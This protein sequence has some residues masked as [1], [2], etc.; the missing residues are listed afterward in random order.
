MRRTLLTLA[1][2]AVFAHAATAEP[3][4]PGPPRTPFAP[5]R[6]LVA[7]TPGTVIAPS[8]TPGG[9][10]RSANVALSAALARQGIVRSRRLSDAVSTDAG[11]GDILL[12]ESD[13]ADFDPLSAAADLRAL[14][15]VTGAAPDLHLQLDLVP[16][17]T[18]LPYQWFFGTTAAGLNAQGGWSLQTGKP[19]VT[20]AILDCGVDLEHADLA[21]N[22]WTNP[23]EIAANGK[24]DDKDGYVDDVHGWDF[25]DG[26]NDPNPDPLIDPSTSVD[27]GWHGTFVAGLAA[28]K[29]NNALGITG[30]AWNCSLMPVKISDING[31]ITLSAAVSGIAYAALKHASVINM[32]IGTTDASAAPVFQAAI[33]SAV[34]AGCA[35]VA[36]AGNSGTDVPQYP[37][38]CTDVVAVAATNYSNVRSSFSNWGAYV[39]IAAPGESMW[40]CIARNYA[41]DDYST[42]VF[43]YY[44]GFDGTHAY[45]LG[46]GTSFAAPIVAGAI[47]LERAQF[48]WL[49][50]RQ[51]MQQIVLDGDPHTFDNPIGP[52]LNLGRALTYALDVA[53]AAPSVLAGLALA[54]PAPNPAAGATTLRFSLPGAGRVR[55]EVFDAEGR[56]VRT[57]AD[58]EYAAGEQT[59]AWDLR[60][61][62]GARVGAGLYFARLV[63][64]VETRTQRIVVTR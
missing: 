32:S 55:L 29:G 50:A 64:G 58:G 30:T 17:D 63:T 19:S 9:T 4:L 49:T 23:G 54:P 16:N 33:N 48:R 42:L 46:D 6:V 44:Y 18:Y 59:T 43:E 57:L 8:A 1:G 52:K 41:Y 12:L 35:I 7:V 61:E 36:A 37:A 10:A 28:A 2:L 22:I 5:G 14:P 27:E 53:P 26:D 60:D 25:G 15:G 47:A 34:S 3:H 51:A 24:D 31:N 56:R 20:I 45:M 40:S 38:A 13:R 39:D 21:P 11:Q 62:A